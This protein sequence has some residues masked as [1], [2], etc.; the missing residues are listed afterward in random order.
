MTK[1]QVRCAIYTRKSSEEGLA[2]PFNSLE[3]QREACIAY[4]QSQKHEGWI[5]VKDRYDDAGFSGGTMERPALKQLLDH[6][7]AGKIETVIVYKID[8]LTRSLADFAKIVEVFDSRD[9]SFVSVTQQFNTTT[10]MGRLTLNVLLS[11]A[12]FERELTGERIR[13]KVAA[14][15]KR[16]MWMGGIVPLGY[17]CVDHRLIVHRSEAETVREIFRQYVRLR[18]VKKLRDV[19]HQ[20]QIRSKARTSKAGRTS[21]NAAYSRGA[22]YHLLNNRVYIGEIIHRDQSYPGQHEAIVPQKLWGQVAERLEANN[23]AHRSRKSPSAPSLLSGIVF[24]INGVRF[25][26]T[27]AVKNGKRYRY[28]TSQAAIQG[29]GD[30]PVVS[31]FPAQELENL[32][33]SQIYLLLG[34]P[35]KC[36]AGLENS[37]EKDFAAERAVDLAKHWSRLEISKQREFVRNVSRRI[38]V[39]RTTACIEVDTAKLIAAL[40]GHSPESTE[41]GA[42]RGDNT[43]KLTADF[44]PL[45]RGSELRLVGPKGSSYEGTPVPS[46]VKAI[47]RARN[48]YEQIVAGQVVTVGQIARETGLS[49]TYVK[50][51]LDCARLSPHI[52]E[53]VLSGKHQPNLT[54]QELLQ[55]VPMDWREQQSRVPPLT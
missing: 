43:I 2:Q 50:R 44:Q 48:W 24:D 53:M 14:S 12:Q 35:D 21:G 30:G 13:D 55:N 25:T 47:A 15:K 27:H 10:S 40:L 11:F 20:R 9:V 54:L 38:V 22:L 34:S 28:Y 26:P 51:I 45:R 39:S 18:C 17:D 52:T 33:T 42:G 16:G 31:R 1:S 29:T 7:S 3:A 41:S 49:S 5:A 19:L 4:I 8:R 37:P 6:I 23:Q 32:V 36:T 46:L